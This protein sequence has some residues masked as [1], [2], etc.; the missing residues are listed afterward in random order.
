MEKFEGLQDSEG[1]QLP[2]AKVAAGLSNMLQGDLAKQVQLLE[3]KA[4]ASGKLFK[5]CQ[6]S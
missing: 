6:I 1:R 5:G 2:D 4:E 3:E